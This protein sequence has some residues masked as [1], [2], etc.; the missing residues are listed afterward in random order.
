M[1]APVLE[2]MDGSIVSVTLDCPCEE[3]VNQQSNR[4]MWQ[5]E[6]SLLP[7]FPRVLLNLLFGLEAGGNEA[8]FHHSMWQIMCE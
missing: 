6:L 4:N 2:I 1:A 5:P 8:N 7:A 3:Q